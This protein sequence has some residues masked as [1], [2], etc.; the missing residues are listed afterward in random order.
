MLDGF[1]ANPCTPFVHLAE[2]GSLS[3][4]ERVIADGLPAKQAVNT[5]VGKGL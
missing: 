4:T 5:K 3:F 2:L 1:R